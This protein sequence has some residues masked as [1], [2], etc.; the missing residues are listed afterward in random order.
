[1][2]RSDLSHPSSQGK[3]LR[4]AVALGVSVGLG[5]TES[6]ALAEDAAQPPQP[7]RSAMQ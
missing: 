6:K 2:S 7:V 3:G 1:M 5:V 4:V